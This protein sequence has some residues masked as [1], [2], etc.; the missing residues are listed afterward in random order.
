MM[1]DDIIEDQ[2]VL[3]SKR[4]EMFTYIES[5]VQYENEKEI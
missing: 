4:E 2:L 5:Q 1:I 3:R